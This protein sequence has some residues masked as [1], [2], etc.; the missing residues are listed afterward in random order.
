M[1]LG[2]EV[3]FVLVVCRHGEFLEF[4]DN[5][6]QSL[7]AD[8]I[9][10]KRQGDMQIAVALIVHAIDNGIGQFKIATQ[11]HALVQLI[12]RKVAPVLSAI[13]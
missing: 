4:T 13:L 12:A 8:F 10:F 1:R 5:R 11:N 3:I 9:L 2:I 7:R 6:A